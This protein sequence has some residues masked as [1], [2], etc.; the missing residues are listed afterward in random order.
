MTVYVLDASA[1]L[2][3]LDKEAG[4][5]RVAAMLAEAAKGSAELAISAIQWGEIAGAVL[6]K[7]SPAVAAHALEMI[8]R[9]TLRIEAV[10]AGRAIRAAALKNDRNIAYA[11]AL[12]L[13]LAMDSPDA[14]LVT[15]DEGFKAVEDLV[16]IEFL[17]AK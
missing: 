13:N 2:R 15:A 7:Q 9:F 12:A 3:L 10:T 11:S 8:S 1:I 14:V 6:K 16:R 4:W 5:E 17:P